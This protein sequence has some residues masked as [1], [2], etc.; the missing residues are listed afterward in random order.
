[1]KKSSHVIESLSDYLLGTLSARK[2]SAVE[3][4]LKTCVPCSAEFKSMTSLWEELGR[5]P[6]ELPAPRI[7]ERF[8]AELEAQKASRRQPAP[9]EPGRRYPIRTLLERFW[10]KQPALQVGIALACLLVGYI[11]GFRIDGVGTGSGDDVAQLRAQVV[12]MQR[13]VMLSLMKTESA[14]ERIRGANWSERI[15]RPDT[16]VYS[17]LFEALNYD[18]VVNVRLAALDPLSKYYNE[19]EVKKG[20]ISSLLR[21]TSPL[22]Q[23]AIIQVITTVHD[24]DAR[25]VLKE[26]LKIKDLN[27][28]VRE[29]AEKRVNE[30]ESEGIR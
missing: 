9:P 26:L 23:L 30:M 18:P 4:H 12:T 13:L 1:M 3:R 22:V 19:P 21:Q 7:R 5:I 14:S 25:T 24:A 8:Y 15:S 28:T 10:P 11:I 27:K 2:R 20:L 29:Q 16:E 17:A 6:D